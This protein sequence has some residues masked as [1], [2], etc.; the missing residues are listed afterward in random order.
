M[1]PEEFLSAL[2]ALGWKQSDFCRMADVNKNTPSRW[3]NGVVPIPGWARRFLAMALE[4]KR[5]SDLID[6][7]MK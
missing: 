6:P 3:V 7:K 1:T 4:I 2:E 5:L